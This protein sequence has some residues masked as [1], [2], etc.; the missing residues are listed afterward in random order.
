MLVLQTPEP[1][2]VVLTS[3]VSAAAV[4]TGVYQIG[5]DAEMSRL[6]G[7]PAPQIQAP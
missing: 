1:A 4:N 3:K 2:V 6:G 7:C 5:A